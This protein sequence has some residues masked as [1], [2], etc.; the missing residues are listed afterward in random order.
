MIALVDRY[1]QVVMQFLLGQ[2]NEGS[3]DGAE[4]GLGG[5]DKSAN[6]SL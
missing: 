5:D 3:G 2:S 1:R 4:N 6:L